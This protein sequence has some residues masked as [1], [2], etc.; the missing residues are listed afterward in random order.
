MKTLFL[1]RHAKTAQNS[2][3][4][5][6]LDRPLIEE[7]RRD[8]SLVGQFLR[9][10]K[11]APDVIISSPAA[12]A[13]Q[14]I[15]LAGE[16]APLSTETRLD[17]RIYEAGAEQLLEVVSEVED[18]VETLLLVGHNPG[19]SDLIELLTDAYT[20]MPTATLARIDLDTDAWNKVRAAK[21]KLAFA[22]TPG[23]N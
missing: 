10:E 4:G 16:A 7:G 13:R 8:A 15:G 14:T 6:D 19:L 20:P 9:R 21:G 23:G 3:T 5:R 11:L 18:G 12:R 1:L 2:P 17:A 22:I